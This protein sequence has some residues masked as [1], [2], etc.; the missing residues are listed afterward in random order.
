MYTE[1]YD[2]AVNRACLVV[3]RCERCLFC[4][5][6]EC[7]GDPEGVERHRQKE[8]EGEK[9]LPESVWSCVMFKVGTHQCHVFLF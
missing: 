2:K 1:G 4:T 8:G 7:G 9:V 5:F 6:R 3:Q